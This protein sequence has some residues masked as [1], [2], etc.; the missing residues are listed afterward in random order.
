[1]TVAFLGTPAPHKGWGTFLR[2]V[3]RFGTVESIKFVHFGADNLTA[4][5]RV[6]T[7]PVQVSPTNPDAMVNA[8]KAMA[9]HVVV[10]WPNWPETYSLVTMEALIAG[11]WVITNS[12]SGNVARLVNKFGG[13][14]VLTSEADLFTRFESLVSEFQ[15]RGTVPAGGAI[16][17]SR[18]SNL[19][20]EVLGA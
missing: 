14:I 4:A 10:I 6:E 17:T 15:Q 1:M 2:L 9:A 13:G 7:V 11:A 5:Y 18:L 3:E 16:K 8:L 19:T 20:Y 12:E